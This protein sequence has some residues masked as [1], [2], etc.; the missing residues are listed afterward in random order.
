[1]SMIHYPNTNPTQVELGTQ[2]NSR[3]KN[4]QTVIDADNCFLP[5]PI[6]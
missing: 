4:L 5:A 6:H 1:M 3:H 2:S